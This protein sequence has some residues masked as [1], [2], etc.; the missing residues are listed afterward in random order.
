MNRTWIETAACGKY[1]TEPSIRYHFFMLMKLFKRIIWTHFYM[2]FLYFYL[3]NILGKADR[4]NI[5][6]K[7][8][9]QYSWAYSR[10]NLTAVRLIHT[11]VFKAKHLLSTIF[12]PFVGTALTICKIYCRYLFTSFISIWLI[13][14]SPKCY[15][16]TTLDLWSMQ[17][18]YFTQNA[19][20]N[21]IFSF[22]SA[23]RRENRTRKIKWKR[24]KTIWW[25]D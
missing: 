5:K 22:T 12:F 9:C 18:Q 7:M 23:T 21:G 4:K 17:M 2:N 19:F 10:N 24:E 13:A 15:R 3:A 11:Y 1:S 6:N 8:I 14:I 25:F 16:T 20:C